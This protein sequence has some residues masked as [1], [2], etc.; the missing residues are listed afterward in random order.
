MSRKHGRDVVASETEEQQQ[1][2]E[3]EEDADA[4]TL[5]GRTVIDSPFRSFIVSSVSL[6]AHSLPVERLPRLT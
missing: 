5:L 1:Q 6:R 3:E 2:E 4:F